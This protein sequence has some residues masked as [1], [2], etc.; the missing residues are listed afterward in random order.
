METIRAFF[1][2]LLTHGEDSPREALAMK[3]QQQ[4]KLPSTLHNMGDV[5]EL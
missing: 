1:P 2:Q 4:L 5:I 3:I